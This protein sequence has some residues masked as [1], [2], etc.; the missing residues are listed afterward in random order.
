MAANVT[1]AGVLVEHGRNA[2]QAP[3]VASGKDG[4]AVAAMCLYQAFALNEPQTPRR[5]ADPAV[6]DRTFASPWPIWPMDWILHSCTSATSCI[7]TLP[8]GGFTNTDLIIEVTLAA[9]GHPAMDHRHPHH[10]GRR[11][12][13]RARPNSTR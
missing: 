7:F 10:G 4:A 8:A 11:R 6:V 1:T 3:D 12:L 13:G 5:Y 9:R 2:G